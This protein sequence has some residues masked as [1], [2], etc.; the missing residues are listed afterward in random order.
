MNQQKF[1]LG[2]VQM[3]MEEDIDDN[4]RHGLDMARQAAKDGAQVICPAGVVHV[5]LF[6]S[7]GRCSAF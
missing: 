6:L 1:T 2:V 3:A 5:A 7:T 4:R